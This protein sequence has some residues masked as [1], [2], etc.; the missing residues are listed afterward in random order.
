MN[1][2]RKV[3]RVAAVLKLNAEN[4]QETAH[5]QEQGRK[6]RQKT[7]HEKAKVNKAGKGIGGGW[8]QRR[9]LL[10]LSMQAA[11]QQE[12]G[13]YRGQSLPRRMHTE[14]SSKAE[15]P[16]CTVHCMTVVAPVSIHSQVLRQGMEVGSPMRMDSVFHRIQE[17]RLCMAT[18][19][20]FS[21]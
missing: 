14:A 15:V 7:R 12:V 20:D 11:Q 13:G 16:L 5:E 2:G 6:K 21:L 19:P 3:G 1:N 10:P 9:E 17:G 8:G 18:N 4:G